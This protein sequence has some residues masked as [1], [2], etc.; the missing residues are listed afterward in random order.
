MR[1]KIL[2][3]V[4][5]LALPIGTVA[6]L[7]SVA[8]AG[9]PQNPISCTG[10]TGTVTF[11]SPLSTAGIATTAKVGNPTL[12][13]GGSF[14]CAGGKAGHAGTISDAGGKNVKLSKSDPRY[15]KAAGIKYTEGTWASFTTAGGSLKKTLKVINFTIGGAAVQFKTK[16]ASE[17]LFGACGSDVGFK[18]GGQV[19]SGT[20]ID[21]TATVLACLGS[22]FGPGASGSFGG[23]YNH[24][25]G[26]D[27]A[28]IDGSVSNATL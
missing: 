24:A 16:S 3:G 8:S 27:G 2:M 17:V 28:N 14:T 9:A 10:F 12:I 23:D 20:Y 21:K 26:V 18:I 15:N 13:T 19:K 1:R 7:S 6:G 4:L 11:G 25:Q 22:D 5:A